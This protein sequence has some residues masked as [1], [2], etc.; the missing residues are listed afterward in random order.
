MDEYSNIVRHCHLKLNPYADKNYYKMM[1][2]E[3]FFKLKKIESKAKEECVKESHIKTKHEYEYERKVFKNDFANGS[4]R[5]TWENIA[6]RQ[7][8][9]RLNAR[10]ISRCVKL[11]MKPETE[12][13]RVELFYHGFIDSLD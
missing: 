2:D 8:E 3:T 7:K 4:D 5:E 6:K 10:S 12:A 13:S 1:T 9:K 11:K